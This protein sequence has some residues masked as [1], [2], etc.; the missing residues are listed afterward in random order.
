[1]KDGL[2]GR[3]WFRPMMVSMMIYKEDYYRGKIGM[4]SLLGEGESF[5]HLAFGTLVL[6]EQNPLR[7]WEA[8]FGVRHPYQQ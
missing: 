5:R 3:D 7:A 4:P 6:R 1:L 8:E 2:K